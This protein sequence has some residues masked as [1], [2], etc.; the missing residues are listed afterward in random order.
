VN[1]KA[2]HGGGGGIE[3]QRLLGE[4]DA[5]RDAVLT[6][7]AQGSKGIQGR[8]VV[9]IDFERV[10]EQRLGLVDLGRKLKGIDLGQGHRVARFQR[11][12]AHGILHEG[13]HFVDPRGL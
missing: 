10:R 7:E 3:L 6:A 13:D 4:P 12:E 2:A 1:K 5:V 8:K 11:V 9:G